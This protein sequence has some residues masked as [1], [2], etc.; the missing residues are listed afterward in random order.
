MQTSPQERYQRYRRYFVNLGQ[1]Y[2]KKKV[3]VYTGIVLSLLVTAFFLFFAIRPTLTTIAGLTKEIKD[4]REIT[5]KLEDKVKA[6]N[7]AQIEYQKAE[8]DLSLIDEGLPRNPNISLLVRQLE[9]LARE[10]GL[11]LKTIQFSETVLRGQEE[12]KKNADTGEGVTF[13]LAVAGDYQNLKSF[14]DLL[15]NLRRSISIEAFAF[16]TG[17]TEARLT[18]NL[19]VNAHYLTKLEE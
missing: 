18:L 10:A 19:N 16:G 9:A 2:Q 5:E 12:T 15:T 4:K 1:L 14:L 8:K 6:L 7:S 17:K 13:S 3:R 11:S